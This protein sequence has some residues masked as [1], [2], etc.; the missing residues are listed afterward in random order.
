MHYELLLIRRNQ[1]T[2]FLVYQKCLH[3]GQLRIWNSGVDSV[4][5]FSDSGVDSGRIRCFPF[6]PGAGVKN[7]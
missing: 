5:F 4:F 2:I 6:G 1:Y 3:Q 7:L